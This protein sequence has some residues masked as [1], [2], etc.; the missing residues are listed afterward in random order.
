MSAALAFA[1]LAESKRHVIQGQHAVSSDPSTMF[2]T[3]LG[4][5]V[6]ACLHDPE[7]GVGGMNHFLLADDA[8]GARVGEAAMRYGAYAMEVLINDLMKRGAR[9]E[10]LEAKLFGG[11]KMIESLQDVGA[12]NA[13]FARRFLEDEDIPLIAASLGGQ[14]ARRVEFWPTTGR[15]RQR[16]VSQAEPLRERAE[17]LLVVGNSVELF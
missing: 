5:C 12:A 15:A 14:R 11:A 17:P 10:R 3:V 8:D 2:T 13:A 4:S 7:R 1:P 6:A 9:R 16:Q